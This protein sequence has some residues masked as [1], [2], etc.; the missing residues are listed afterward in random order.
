VLARLADGKLV[1]LPVRATR[2]PI[3]PRLTEAGLFYAYIDQQA[4][5]K[6]RVVFEPATRLLS[7]F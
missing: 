7:R 3:D 6:R 4:P 1:S 2:R 5:T